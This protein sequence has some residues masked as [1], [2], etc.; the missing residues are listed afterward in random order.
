VRSDYETAYELETDEDALKDIK[1][2]VKKVREQHLTF[3]F[4]SLAFCALEVAHRPCLPPASQHV[5]SI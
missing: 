3:G 5:S 1:L 4:I 2:K